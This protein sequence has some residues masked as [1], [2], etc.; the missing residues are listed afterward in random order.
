MVKYNLVRLG[1]AYP[2][3]GYQVEGLVTVQ[4]MTLYFIEY[5]SETIYRFNSTQSHSIQQLF[6]NHLSGNTH[7]VF[8]KDERNR[9]GNSV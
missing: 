1:V 2:P 5:T 9:K 3:G 6:V 4:C 7:I 8:S